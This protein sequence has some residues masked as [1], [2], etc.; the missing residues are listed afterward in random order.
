[1]K[2]SEMRSLTQKMPDPFYH[3]ESAN[4]MEHVKILGLD[5]TSFH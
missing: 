2:L 3:V 5:T 4:M 1:M